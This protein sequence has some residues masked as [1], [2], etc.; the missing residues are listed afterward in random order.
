MPINNKCSFLVQIFKHLFKNGIK[1]M[2]IKNEL[3]YQFIPK[4]TGKKLLMY[5][6]PD[7]GFETN[8]NPFFFYKFSNSK[9]LLATV[10]NLKIKNK[11][12]ISTE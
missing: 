4:I 2:K 1:N 7:K 6:I 12:P 11:V 8:V 9:L 5:S 3:A 10:G